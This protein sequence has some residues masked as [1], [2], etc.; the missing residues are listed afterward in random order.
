MSD[1]LYGHCDNMRWGD[2]VA[3]TESSNKNDL[4]GMLRHKEGIGETTAL[5][6]ACAR[7]VPNNILQAMF[8]NTIH[9]GIDLKQILSITSNGGW[10]V[11]T[12]AA[13]FCSLDTLKLVVLH[14]PATALTT[15]T[16][17]GET[18]LYWARQLN[19]TENVRFLENVSNVIWDV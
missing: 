19:K 14:S 15:R 17:Y 18:P 5:H 9:K 10:L 4:E 1:V 12:F 16:T 2:A 11:L 6:Y 7:D 13:G 8:T 3:L